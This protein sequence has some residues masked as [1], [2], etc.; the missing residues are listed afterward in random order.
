M[1]FKYNHDVVPYPNNSHATMA[2]AEIS[3]RQVAIVSSGPWLTVDDSFPNQ[4]LHPWHL[5]ILKA[6]EEDASCSDL[7]EFFVDCNQHVWNLQQW[8]LTIYLWWAA[9]SHGSSL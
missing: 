5:P 7:V 9:K 8:S 4:I 3:S 2:P 1:G 6:T